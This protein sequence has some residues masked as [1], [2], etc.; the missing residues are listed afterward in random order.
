MRGLA[1]ILVVLRHI[2]AFILP[3]DFP[4]SGLAVDL[5]FILSGVVIANSYEDRIAAGTIS[6]RS[7]AAARIIRIYPLYLIASVFGLVGIVLWHK[8]APGQLLIACGLGVVMLPYPLAAVQLFPLDHPAWSL[9]LEFVANFFY[10]YFLKLLNDR[11]L[12]VIVILSWLV[13]LAYSIHSGTPLAMIGFTR[14]TIAIG[15]ARVFASFFMGVLIYRVSRNRLDLF[16]FGNGGAAAVLAATLAALMLS[17]GPAW[18]WL[19]EAA[20]AMLVFPVLVG[21]AICVHTDGILERAIR[22]L[23]KISYPVYVLHVPIYMLTLYAFGKYLAPWAPYSGLAYV[24]LV[25]LVAFWVDRL[26]D[27]PIRARLKHLAG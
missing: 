17:T 13:L 15:V 18:L 27:V 24:A 2:S 12:G 4:S 20:V 8:L 10:G 19:Y 21:I 16:R 7:F 5:F 11:N 14:G 9:F 1:A 22:A 6:F 26:V 23:G 25:S 3:I